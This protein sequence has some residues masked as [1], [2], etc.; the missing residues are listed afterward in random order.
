[1]VLSCLDSALCVF[2]GNNVFVLCSIRYIQRLR[3]VFILLALCPPFLLFVFCYEY[4]YVCLSDYFLLI[5][6]AAPLSGYCF[7]A[8]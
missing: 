6:L 1:M 4:G 3:V 5:H 8:V 7:M 2:C